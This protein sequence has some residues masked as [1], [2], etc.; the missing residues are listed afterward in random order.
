MPNAI[1]MFRAQRDAAD[2][3]HARLTDVAGLLNELQMRRSSHV[4]GNRQLR[5]VLHERADAGG[6]HGDPADCRSD[7]SASRRSRGIWPAVWRRWVLALVFA[8]ASAAAAGAGY[9]WA[10][11]PYAAELDTLRSRAALADENRAPCPHDDAIRATPARCAHQVAE[12]AEVIARTSTSWDGSRGKAARIA[13]DGP[14]AVS[15]AAS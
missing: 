8:L 1:E 6:A 7:T 9:A 10:T 11:R 12:T 3:V 15:W 5:D 2:Q 13:S 4:A 14:P